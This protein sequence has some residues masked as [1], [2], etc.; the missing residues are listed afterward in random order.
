MVQTVLQPKIR[1]TARRRVRLGR[2]QTDDAGLGIAEIVEAL[3]HLIDIDGP[4][5]AT[6]II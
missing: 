6:I 2:A 3:V 5:G 1:A 4:V